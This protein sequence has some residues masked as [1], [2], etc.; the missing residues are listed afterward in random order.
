MKPVHKQLNMKSS[1]KVAPVSCHC[2]LSLLIVHLQYL[3]QERK[4]TARKNLIAVR[5]EAPAP[6]YHYV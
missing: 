2:K 4:N 6:V 1:S 3:A 5:S